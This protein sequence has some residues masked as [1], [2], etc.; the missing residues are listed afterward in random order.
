MEVKEQKENVMNYI[1]SMDGENLGFLD[2]FEYSCEPINTQIMDIGGY[3]QQINLGQHRSLSGS[4]LPNEN[5]IVKLK[6]DLFS[7]QNDFEII[8]IEQF[9]KYVFKGFFVDLRL[10]N[11][12][13][14]YML[15]FIIKLLSDFKMEGVEGNINLE[16]A[17]EEKIKKEPKYVLPKLTKPVIIK[18]DKEEVKGRKIIL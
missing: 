12:F 14:G 9:L 17:I 18:D 6:T 10:H 8:S 4:L 2:K 16:K 3:T 1:L 11:N 13:D 15:D 7:T 5:M